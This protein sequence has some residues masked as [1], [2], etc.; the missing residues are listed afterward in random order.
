[1]IFVLLILISF[2]IYSLTVV[3]YKK[4]RQTTLYAL[5]IGG[6]VNANFFHALNYPIYCF[7][8]PFGLNNIIY[9]LFAFWYSINCYK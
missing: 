4:F 9:P 5:A 1:M 2:L 7:G 8:L 6:A 3:G